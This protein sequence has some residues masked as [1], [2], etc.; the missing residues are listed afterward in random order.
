GRT[1]M[2]VGN[3]KYYLNGSPQATSLA[4]YR[5]TGSASSPAFELADANWLNVSAYGI[6]AAFP[7]LYDA[8]QDGDQDLFIGDLSGRIMH[9]ERLSNATTADAFQPLGWMLDA[10]GDTIDVGQ[11][12]SPQWFDVDG[13]S[14]TDF[15]SGCL[16]G[17]VWWY[18]GTAQ[19]L[20]FMNDS[21]GDA[22]ATS[23]LGIQ[24]RSIPEF[25]HHESGEVR[26]LLGSETGA[27]GML[28][29]I[30]SNVNGTFE[31]ITPQFENI[32]VGE[33]SAASMA[34]IN[35]DGLLDIV[36]GN[37]DGGLQW[38]THL[39]LGVWSEEIKPVE[40][41]PTPAND[42]LN[43]RWDESHIGSPWQV[44]DMMGRCIAQGMITQSSMSINVSEW[45]SG[46][47][48]IR[49][50]DASRSMQLTRCIVAH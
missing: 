41:F 21:L 34:D 8:D 13:D 26:L 47:Y 4:F 12:A 32:D 22:V 20:Q 29:Q 17:S 31:W 43:M 49:T 2:V 36:V 40:V 48:M 5:N 19:G 38:Y 15:V 25:F 35:G 50:L 7:C 44:L 39:P 18:Q 3:R 1:D 9:V 23:I 46:C 16:N 24:G 28:D 27:L 11:F 33:R 30:T 6:Q 37:L 45:G 42:I 14:I 10:S